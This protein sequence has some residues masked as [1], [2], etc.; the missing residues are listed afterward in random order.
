M[1]FKILFSALVMMVS[2][3]QA[4]NV[5]DTAPDFTHNTLDHGQIT[6]SQYQGKV[7]FLFFFGHN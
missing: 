7:V 1:N 5:G 2:V 4:Q 3:L 6:L